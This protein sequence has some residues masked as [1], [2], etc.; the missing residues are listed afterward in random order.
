MCLFPVVQACSIVELAAQDESQHEILFDFGVA[1][2]LE[3][4]I[5]N[6]FTLVG[7]S[8]A[9][10]ASG[11]GVTLVGRNEGGKVLRR[12]AVHAVLDRLYINLRPGTMWSD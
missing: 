4:A 8:V 7:I 6:D 10:Y 5:L 3:Y 11:A 2:A 1:D 12:E 9:A